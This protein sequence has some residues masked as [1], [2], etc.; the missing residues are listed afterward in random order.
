AHKLL[1]NEALHVLPGQCQNTLQNFYVKY[2]KQESRGLAG[3]SVMIL[4]GTVEKDD[5]LRAL[6]I[7]ESGHNIDL[8]CLTGTKESGKS[9]FS[10]SDE[11]I[12]NDDPSLQYY[13]ISWLTSGVQKSNARPEDFVSGYASYDIWEDFS[14]GFAYFVLQNEAFAARAETNAALAKK[15]AFFRDVLFNGEAPQVATG[16]SQYKG[17][18]PWDVTKLAYT[19]HP[20][21]HVAIQE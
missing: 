5:E 15:Y 18:A 19:W 6:F 4:D 17:K 20:E 8:G 16:L 21:M 1:F 9:A 2:E 7:H 3:K 11:P 14:E 13:T 12:Y 10:D